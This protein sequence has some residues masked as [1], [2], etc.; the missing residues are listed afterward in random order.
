MQH[1]FIQTYYFFCYISFFYVLKMRNV[2]KKLSVDTVPMRC[3]DEFARGQGKL[4]IAKNNM[5]IIGASEGKQRLFIMAALCR[6]SRQNGGQNES[7]TKNQAARI[8]KKRH[9][10]EIYEE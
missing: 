10:P 7:N 8:K 5:K 3:Y 1:F 6:L 2:Y 9:N 4:F